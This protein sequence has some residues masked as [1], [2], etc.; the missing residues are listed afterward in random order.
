[1]FNNRINSK[2]SGFTLIELLV[3]VAIIGIL[4][5]VVIASL[6]GAR[7]KGKIAT[8]KSTLRQLYNQAALNQLEVGSFTGSNDA[9]LNC[10]GTN[11]N[12]LK[13]VQSLIDQGII[14]KCYSYSNSTYNDVYQRFGA[15]ALIYDTTELKAW[16]VDE[17]GVVK[18]DTHGVDSYGVSVT[19]DTNSGMRWL[20]S[21]NACSTNGGR[22][23]SIEQLIT[24]SFAWY[25]KANTDGDV[26]PYA[27]MGF[28]SSGYWSSVL[29]PSDELLAY[30]V[31][32]PNGGIYAY[33][34]TSNSL[35]TRCVR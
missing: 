7:E 2:N 12:L 16:S 20:I 26:D 21:K 19:P 35:F 6:N 25:S 9:S 5:T 23:P 22:L 17:N 4:S 11:N 10:T 24:L 29:T 8:I 13:I 33:S 15:T 14:V 27:P 31:H 18:W 28:T 1:M 3:V 30:I 32:L 34:P